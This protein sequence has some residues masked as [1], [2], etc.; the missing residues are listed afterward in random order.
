Y[1]LGQ[2]EIHV[3][4][5]SITSNMGDVDEDK[6]LPTKQLEQVFEVSQTVD[7]TVLMH[8]D[9]LRGTFTVKNV[10]HD[11]IEIG[12][13]EYESVP[14][15]WV[16]FN[17]LGD[18]YSVTYKEPNMMERYWETLAPGDESSVFF[19]MPICT[20]GCYTGELTIPGEYY[21]IPMIYPVTGH[22]Y[23]PDI[24][25]DLRQFLKDNHFFIFYDEI[26]YNPHINLGRLGYLMITV[27]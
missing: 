6:Y 16:F 27:Q 11:T 23:A 24:P 20:T 14:R 5:N 26:V 9:Y 19:V 18:D 17:V 12:M 8:G 4:G 13:K 1:D 10:Y 25:T 15:D 2:L 3:E 7:K 21:F 22:P